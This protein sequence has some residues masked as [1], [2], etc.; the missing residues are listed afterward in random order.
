MIIRGFCVTVYNGVI[1]EIRGF[2]CF[3][4]LILF[5]VYMFVGEE[6]ESY[7]ELI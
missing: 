7:L 3:Y 5:V 4:E 2:H 6:K 1:E